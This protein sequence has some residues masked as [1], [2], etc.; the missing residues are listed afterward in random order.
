VT[1]VAAL[2]AA[3]AALGYGLSDFLGGQVT[4][5]LPVVLTL[6]LS[7]VV[8]VWLFAVAVLGAR[9]PVPD[10][11]VLGL[12]AAAGVCG[13]FGLVLLYR[14][15][16]VGPMSVVAPT[17]AIAVASVPVLAALGRGQR[18]TP[19]VGAGAAA[20]LVA[21]PLLA[22]DRSEEERRGPAGPVA[23]L[24]GGTLLGLFSVLLA[25]TPSSS[26]LWPLLAER[27]ATVVLIVPFT[28]YVALRRRRRGRGGTLYD[29][30]MW[31]LAVTGGL[32]ESVAD[33][34]VLVAVRI[35]LLIAGPVI[36]LYPAVTIVCA[37]LVRHERIPWC[38]RFG[39]VIAAAAVAALTVGGTT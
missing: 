30:G 37:R 17:A 8:G 7:Q 38:R 21:I 3:V 15:L 23:A 29:G 1:V 19:L 4:R 26:G 22:G 5:R 27:V 16:A 9:T 18:P 11:A 28:A 34:A 12:G 24:V 31:S 6:L 25:A 35:D 13:T 10:P 2:A 36:A 20:A 39:L 33:V 32:V 14:A